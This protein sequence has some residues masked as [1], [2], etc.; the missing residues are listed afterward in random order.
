M[1]SFTKMAVFIFCTIGFFTLLFALIPP[2]FFEASYSASIGVD[3]EIAEYFAVSNV[4]LYGN[5]GSDNMTYSYSSYDHHPDAP[6]FGTGLPENQ[7]LEVWWGQELTPYPT[8]EFRHIEVGWWRT[9]L[10]YLRFELP[11]KTRVWYLNPELLELAYD[12]A[13]NG[14]AYYTWCDH[15]SVSTIITFNQTAYNNITE[16]W[17]DGKLSYIL[18]YEPNWN[19]SSVSAFTIMAQLLTFQNPDL[20]IEGDAGTIFNFMVAA[21]FWIMTAI[22]IL[23]VIQSLVPFIRGIDA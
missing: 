3:K 9:R 23:I 4:T 6:Q 22:L 7:Y 21:P 13:I 5:A 1:G 15:I 20:G 14:S 16:A 19:A 8:L 18:S 11:N 10:D 2:Q 17:D 12:D